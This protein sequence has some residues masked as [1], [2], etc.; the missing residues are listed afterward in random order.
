MNM[1]NKILNR[2]YTKTAGTG[3]VAIVLCV[4]AT[5][6]TKNTD[7]LLLLIPVLAGFALSIL[8]IACDVKNGN[9][10]SVYAECFSISGKNGFGAGKR[11]TY[12]FIVQTETGEVWPDDNEDTASIFIK[13]E[14][15]KFRPCFKNKRDLYYFNKMAMAP[16]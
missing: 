5:I 8:M 11:R 3:V 15:G 12:R 9:I 7:N 4:V 10:I 1:E 6:L 13:A 2:L 16:M 14:N